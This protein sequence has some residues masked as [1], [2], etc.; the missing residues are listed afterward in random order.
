MYLQSTDKRKLRCT[1]CHEDIPTGDWVF[2][3]PR[4]GVYCH[5]HTPKDRAEAWSL[6]KRT[7]VNA[8]EQRGDVFL[9]RDVHTDF[10]YCS[11]CDREFPPTE[12]TRAKAAKRRLYIFL[13]PVCG[14][15]IT[16]MAKRRVLN[17]VADGASRIRK[18]KRRL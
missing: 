3:L 17:E 2:W 11:F 16:K 4:A 7:P 12:V 13:C 15:V 9:G 6:K 1:V 10:W 5:K 8:N 18:R 14:G